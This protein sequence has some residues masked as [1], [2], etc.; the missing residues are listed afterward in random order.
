MT[1]RIS[2][3]EALGETFAPPSTDLPTTSA[4]DHLVD[5]VALAVATG[6]R[7][8][9]LAARHGYTYN[10]M[11]SL[12]ESEACQDR[13]AT[14]RRRIGA[15]VGFA[16]QKVMLNLG[17]LTDRELSIAMPEFSEDTP[18][19]VKLK[20]LSSAASQ[21]ARHYLI[22]KVW[23]TVTQVDNRHEV[24]A[25]HETVE[26]L[27]EFRALMTRMK[28]ERE[29]RTIDVLSSPHVYEGIDAL[30]SPLAGKVAIAEAERVERDGG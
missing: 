22:D 9:V 30:P 21:R 24:V 26:V 15:E 1:S 2:A 28:E 13:I 20:F 19:E 6:T 12:I 4:R 10:G 8:S 11:H 5:V 25:N 7:C 3:E 16:Q 14:Y 18:D 17:E 23:P 27:T 29:V